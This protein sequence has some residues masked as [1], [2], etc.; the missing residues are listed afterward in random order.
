MTYS[1]RGFVPMTFGMDPAPHSP[2]SPLLSQVLAELDRTTR[3]DPSPTPH[4]GTWPEARLL[5]EA[6]TEQEHTEP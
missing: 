4:P 6:L 2:G 1:G 3:T 5:V